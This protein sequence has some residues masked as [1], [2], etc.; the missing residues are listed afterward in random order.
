M[1]DN[2]PMLQIK[3]LFTLQCFRVKPQNFILP[4]YAKTEFALPENG[5][6]W[7]QAPEIWQRH[8]LYL[9]VG[10]KTQYFENGCAYGCSQLPCTS[11]FMHN[12]SMHACVLAHHKITPP[13]TT[14][15]LYDSVSGVSSGARSFFFSLPVQNL[16]FDSWILWYSFI[17]L[18]TCSKWCNNKM[19]YFH[20]VKVW[21]TLVIHLHTSTDWWK[22]WGHM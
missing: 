9:H 7:K 14:W 16:E 10:R 11:S 20:A 21:F 4:V 22:M 13:A 19:H 18:N 1:N 17:D 6:I 3:A 5:I 2:K 8:R 12:V 15:H